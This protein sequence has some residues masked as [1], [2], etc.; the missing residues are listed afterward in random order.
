MS[1]TPLIRFHTLWVGRRLGPLSVACLSSFVAMGHG[2]TVHVYDEAPEDVPPGVALSDASLV[3]PRERIMLHRKH[4]S[5]ALFSDLFRLMLQAKGVG[6]WIDCD[7]LCVRPIRPSGPNLF[8]LESPHSIGNSILGLPTDSPML[9]DLI[10]VFDHGAWIPPWFSAS[11]AFRYRL[12]RLIGVHR[13]AT[14]L[15]WAATGPAALTWYAK[16]AGLFGH[17]APPEVFY[18]VPF[19]EAALLY[20]PAYD[21]AAAIAPATLGVHLWNN[22]LGRLDVKTPPKGSAIDRILSGERFRPAAA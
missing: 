18:P 21:L 22:M 3:A 5:V 19:G 9:A 1:D 4:Q 2:V 10:A 14:T 15:P 6:P 8:G 20:D 12:K 11:R 13:D 16:Q 7:I 17:A